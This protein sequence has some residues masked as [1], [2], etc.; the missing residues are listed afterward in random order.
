MQEINSTLNGKLE[1]LE[2]LRKQP[3]APPFKEMS[4]NELADVLSLTIKHDYENKLVT[5]LCMLSAYTHSNQINVSFNAPSSSGKSYLTT[6]VAKLFPKEDKIE[7]S[8]ASPTS[9]F[10]GEGVID[11]NRKAKIVSLSRKILIFYEQPD[12]TLQAK[13]RSVLSHDQWETKYRITN[14]GQKGEHRAQLIIMQGFPATVFCSAGMRLDEQEATRAILLS[15]EVTESK[16][17]EGVHLQAQRGANEVAFKSAINVDSKRIALKERILAIRDEEVDDI[18]ITDSEAVEKR[19]YKKLSS[20]KPR[21][22]RDMAHL[23]KLI[24]AIALLNVWSRKK[25]SHS[26][27]ASEDDIDQAFELWGY[28]IESQDLNLPPVLMNF[29]KK[30]ILPAFNEKKDEDYS[31]DM[32]DG[33]V[34]ITRHDVARYYL[35]IE[36]TML[37]DEQLRRQILPQL[38]NSGMIMQQK[39]SEGDKRSWHIFPQWFPE[40]NNIGMAQGATSADE[41]KEIIEI[42]NNLFKD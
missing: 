6:E 2:R 30:Y 1:K 13:L 17:K 22:M 38:E 20:V 24:K 36:H 23:M 8:G 42:A 4:L 16:L 28:F 33:K 12:P 27:E 18:I 25:S 31:G 29:Y 15:P 40:K 35:K 10:H 26:Y 7:L 9:F 39:P 34:G 21:H 37:N 3:K 11:K 5:F 14:K 19:F 41:A 32:E